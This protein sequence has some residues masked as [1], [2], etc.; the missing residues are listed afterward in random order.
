MSTPG[1]NTQAAAAPL[2]PNLRLGFV[3]PVAI[4]PGD[5]HEASPRDS[6]RDVSGVRAGSTTGRGQEQEH[7][8]QGES[9]QHDEAYE[10]GRQCV[11]VTV[12]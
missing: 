9:D 2:P 5:G 8:Q 1:N 10:P 4:T 11:Q 12:R 7:R 6:Y 3:T